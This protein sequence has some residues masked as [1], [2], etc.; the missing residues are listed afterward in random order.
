MDFL[1]GTVHLACQPAMQET[2]HLLIQIYGE[3]VFITP[4][5]NDKFFPQ[6]KYC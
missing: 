4:P 6:N 2:R 3:A 5:P 1:T